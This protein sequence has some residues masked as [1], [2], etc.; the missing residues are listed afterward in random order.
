MLSSSTTA[1]SYLPAGKNRQAGRVER[2]GRSGYSGV[3]AAEGRLLA[4]SLL[5][6]QAGQA[7]SPAS[8]QAS[9]IC[10]QHNNT[11]STI[12]VV[13]AA[14]SLPPPL[15]L[16]HSLASSWSS[17]T[18]RSLALECSSKLRSVSPLVHVCFCGRQERKESQAGRRG[19]CVGGSTVLRTQQCPCNPALQ[20][21]LQTSALTHQTVGHA[22]T[23]GHPPT[24]RFPSMRS[25]SGVLR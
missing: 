25:S 17:P 23:L 19:E 20:Q 13:Q 24:C 7:A 12:D 1:L 10:T 2:Q 4:L 8:S 21:F 15:P 3:G 22:P 16:P 14:L 5:I 11:N 9:R 18:R 6:L